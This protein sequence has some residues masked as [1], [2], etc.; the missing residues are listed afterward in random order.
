ME[1]LFFPLCISVIL[2]E[3]RI[4]FV[5]FCVLFY[6]NMLM[7]IMIMM[8]RSFSHALNFNLMILL[9]INMISGK[10]TTC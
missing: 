8:P 3:K 1:I 4:K 6:F 2:R 9:V 7:I 10:I 5:L